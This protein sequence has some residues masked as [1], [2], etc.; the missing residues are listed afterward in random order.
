LNRLTDIHGGAGSLRPPRQSDG[1][2]QDS[3]AA[4]IIG[5]SCPKDCS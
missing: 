3:A 1:N 4:R 5:C 2:G